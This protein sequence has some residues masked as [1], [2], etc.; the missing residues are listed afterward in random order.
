MAS[1]AYKAS[2]D[3]ALR[4]ALTGMDEPAYRRHHRHHAT[5]IVPAYN[6]QKYIGNLLRTASNQTEPF[7]EIVV[8]DCSDAE[9]E[10]AEIARSWDAQ[11]IRVPKGNISASRNAGAAR[12]SGE[13]LVFADADQIL[14][15]NFLE[16]AVDALD[17]GAVLA[18][19][20]LAIYDSVLWH[21]VIHGPQMIRMHGAPSCVA[22]RARDFQGVG[23]YSVDCNLLANG[24]CHED[25]EFINRAVA[26]YGSG[27][28]KLLNTYI[29]TSARRYNRFGF[30]GY[31]DNFATPVRSYQT[32]AGY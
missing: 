13:I 8:A 3:D 4:V 19:P 18:E 23:G 2:A 14:S 28:F 21:M 9:D 22:I 26:T 20:R 10:T 30:S 1:I 31:G 24:H 32:V 25:T 15:S 6:E 27:A 16:Q 5:L 12:A 29:G 17:S 11:V 7:T